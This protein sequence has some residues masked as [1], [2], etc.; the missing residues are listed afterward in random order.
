MSVTETQKINYQAHKR[1]QAQ[2]RQ[3][4]RKP[5]SFFRAFKFPPYMDN[6]LRPE[7]DTVAISQS[8]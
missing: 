5:W 7:E 2:V 8:S 6:G 4:S 3:R 1:I